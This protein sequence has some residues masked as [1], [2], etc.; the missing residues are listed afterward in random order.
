MTSGLTIWGKI[1]R[2][3]ID[4]GC[5]GIDFNENALLRGCPKCQYVS[6]IYRTSIEKEEKQEENEKE[7]RTLEK[8]LADLLSK[9]YLFG[10]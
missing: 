3:G 1:G 10:L 2:C 5:P 8:N 6:N 4:F 9:S 7:K